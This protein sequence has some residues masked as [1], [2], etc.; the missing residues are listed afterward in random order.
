ML[1]K[2]DST[3]IYSVPAAAKYDR[4]VQAIDQMLSWLFMVIPIIQLV[5]A[6]QIFNR[7]G[8]LESFFDFLPITEEIMIVPSFALMAFEI[9]LPVFHILKV[10]SY[11]FL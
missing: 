4:L 7:Y 1:L 10:Y 11:Q 5:Y 3:E 2:M 9:L 8:D 6:L